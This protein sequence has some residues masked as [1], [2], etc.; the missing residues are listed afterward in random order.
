MVLITVDE[1]ND[2]FAELT[3]TV[4]RKIIAIAGMLEALEA[5]LTAGDGAGALASAQKQITDIRYWTRLAADVEVQRA[6][7][8]KEEFGIARAY[9]LDLDAARYEVGRLLAE[10]AARSGEDGV[11]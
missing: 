11:S 10:R 4:E 2:P 1:L 6:K 9:A 5:E 7:R 3:E 8:K